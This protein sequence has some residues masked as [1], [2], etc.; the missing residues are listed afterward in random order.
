MLQL[1]FLFL[2]QLQFKMV[3]IT[4]HFHCKYNHVKWFVIMFSNGWFQ[5]YFGCNKEIHIAYMLFPFAEFL[6]SSFLQTTK[7]YILPRYTP[8]SRPSNVAYTNWYYGDSRY[9]PSH[10]LVCTLVEQ[11]SI[12]ERTDH[13]ENIDRNMCLALNCHGTLCCSPWCSRITME[14][15]TN[16]LLY[17][18]YETM[19][20]K[21]DYWFG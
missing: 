16:M 12:H 10:R 8:P 17:Q 1:F 19:Q 20:P 11:D 18:D 14:E 21:V 7:S 4:D 2:I 9:R 3:R 15:L 6:C 13:A 5:W